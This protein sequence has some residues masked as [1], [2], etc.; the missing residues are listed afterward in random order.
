MATEIHFQVL[1]T[2]YKHMNL[3]IGILVICDKAKPFYFRP[4]WVSTDFSPLPEAA[5]QVTAQWHPER[6]MREGALQQ[7]QA[8]C[9]L[10][11]R[12]HS[13]GAGLGSECSISEL[14]S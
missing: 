14:N 7:V 2:V 8:W 6:R 1:K 12:A 3:C 13:W 4:S 5:S 11:P 9:T 10:R